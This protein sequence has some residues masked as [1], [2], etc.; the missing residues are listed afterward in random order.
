MRNHNIAKLSVGMGAALLLGASAI[1][2]A[3]TPADDPFVT[4]M[5]ATHWAELSGANEVPANETT[6][7]GT[8]W[9]LVDPQNNTIRWH[10]EYEGLTG[11]VTGAHFHGPAAEGENAG[12]VISLVEG[13]EPGALDSPIEGETG[14]LTADQMAEITGGM[15][16]VNLHTEANPGG[17]IRG[18]VVANPHMGME[19]GAEMTPEPMAP[20]PANP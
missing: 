2:I 9:I 19:D 5:S 17:E 12:V 4:E 14:G 11:P 7:T 13:A 3:Q 16:Y 18:Q 20:A 15:W 8:A 10:V 1:A 6:G